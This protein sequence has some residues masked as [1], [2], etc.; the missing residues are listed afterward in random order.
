[1]NNRT[2]INPSLLHVCGCGEELKDDL[3][4]RSMVCHKCG[5]TLSL[6]DRIELEML[7]KTF[8]E[9]AQSHDIE[10]VKLNSGGPIELDEAV[11]PTGLLPA[12]VD[13]AAQTSLLL[14]PDKAFR[15]RIKEYTDT[16]VMLCATH[17]Y[18]E[19]NTESDMS[20]TEA[21]PILSHT[22]QRLIEMSRLDDPHNPFIND[23]R[24][25]SM[26]ELAMGFKPAA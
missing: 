5:S 8:F 7:S 2:T 13:R 3:R 25:M 11:L 4:N 15:F 17:L 1:M 19:R 6:D 14:S 24:M 10:G 20:M 16:N 9:I 26:T 23:L 12:I 22:I 18:V 21:L